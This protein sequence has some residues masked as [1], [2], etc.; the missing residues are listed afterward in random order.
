MT[1]DRERFDRIFFYLIQANKGQ[2][3]WQSHNYIE[4]AMI[5]VW[6]LLDALTEISSAPAGAESSNPDAGASDGQTTERE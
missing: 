6:L 2:M 5:E 4:R 3:D 1:I